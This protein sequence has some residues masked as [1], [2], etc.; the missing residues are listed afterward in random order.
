MTS[1][2]MIASSVAELESIRAAQGANPTT[3]VAASIPIQIGLGCRRQLHVVAAV[4]G[5]ATRFLRAT[6]GVRNLSATNIVFDRSRE[7]LTFVGIAT[8]STIGQTAWFVHCSSGETGR[9]RTNLLATSLTPTEP[10]GRR[11]GRKAS[12]I[13]RRTSGGH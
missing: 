1:D 10:D 13:S 12:S 9:R 4:P 6:F 8:A 2:A 11:R 5:S 3:V 7:N